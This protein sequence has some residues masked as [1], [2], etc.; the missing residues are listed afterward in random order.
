REY[1]LKNPILDRDGAR[2]DMPVWTFPD[3]AAYRR[4]LAWKYAVPLT[5]AAALL[6]PLSLLSKIDRAR[7]RLKAKRAQVELLRYYV[8]IYSPYTSIESRYYTTNTQALW[9]S[10][11]AE[12]QKDFGFDPRGIDWRDYLGNIHIPG[13]KRNVLN[14][15]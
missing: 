12:E 14:L 11:S 9:N 2:I 1:F 3:P 13:L 5:L 6:R 7:R 4:K 10:L 8:D 15:S